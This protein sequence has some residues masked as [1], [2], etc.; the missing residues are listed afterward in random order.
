MAWNIENIQVDENLD[1]NPELYKKRADAASDKGLY[2]EAI[3]EID[4]ALEYSNAALEYQYFRA[5]ILYKAE[6]FEE[7]RQYIMKSDLWQCENRMEL[8]NMKWNSLFTMYW[9]CCEKVFPRGMGDDKTLKYCPRC[10]WKL[11]KEAN[12]CPNC[13]LLLRHKE[14][15]KGSR[16]LDNSTLTVKITTEQM[17]NQ[18]EI[19]IKTP[20]GKIAYKLSSNMDL[21]KKY[22]IKEKGYNNSDL[23]L[24]FIV[25]EML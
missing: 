14:E 23:Y 25:K 9:L 7:C 5:N 1:T 6:R 3:K 15:K 24:K 17:K 8:S 10:G 19:I 20:Q 18:E 4:K 22:R 13:K 2:D 16:T 21:R 11:P 12:Y